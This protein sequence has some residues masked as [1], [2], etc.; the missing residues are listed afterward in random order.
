MFKLVQPGP[1]YTGTLLLP[2]NWQSGGSCPTGMISWLSL[3]SMNPL[4]PANEIWGQGNVFTHV[5]HSVHRGG[6]GW[7]PSMHHRSHNLGVYIQGWG[8]ASR[9]RG[10]VSGGEGGCIQ[11]WGFVSGGGWTDPPPAELGKRAVRILLECF[12]VE[13]HL[14]KT[15]LTRLRRERMYN[16]I[17][18]VSV[19]G[20]LFQRSRETSSLRRWDWMFSCLKA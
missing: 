15:Q 5:C 7:L 13:N 3:N 20:K 6:G 18:L 10:Y 11:G 1:R 19:W 9:G 14:A 16:C 2:D 8:S 12:L 4:P 17:S